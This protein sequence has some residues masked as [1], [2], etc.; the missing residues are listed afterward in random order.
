MTVST[1]RTEDVLREMSTFAGRKARQE[2]FE[3]RYPP[4]PLA[5]CVVAEDERVIEDQHGRPIARERYRYWMRKYSRGRIVA[6]QYGDGPIIFEAPAA[7]TPPVEPN[8]AGY[9]IARDSLP[10]R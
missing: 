3:R 1:N 9:V 2:E 6:Y 10:W 4:N 7:P 5:G 8:R